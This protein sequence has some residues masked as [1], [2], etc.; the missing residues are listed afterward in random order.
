ML[1]SPSINTGFPSEVGRGPLLCT[2]IT[3]SQTQNFSR[4][5]D[6]FEAP[7]GAT[8]QR[9]WNKAT[10]PGLLQQR[11]FTFIKSVMKTTYILVFF[12]LELTPFMMS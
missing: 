8:E 7:V 2:C 10:T 6:Q 12:L 1:S 11:P 9:Y 3:D 4:T 5:Y